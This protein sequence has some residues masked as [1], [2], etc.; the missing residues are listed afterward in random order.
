MKRILLTSTA[1]IAL[2]GTAFAAGH[3]TDH[4]VNIAGDAEI[5]FNDDFE[6]G[7]FYSFGATIT[8]SAEL[9][10]GLTAAASGDVALSDDKNTARASNVTIDDFVMSLTSDTAGLYFGDTPTAAE[11]L[12]SGVTNM[13]FD[14]FVEDGDVDDAA[15][16]DVTGILRGEMGFG[17]F[18]LG[19]SNVLRENATNNDLSVSQI[20]AKGAFGNFSVA[21]AHQTGETTAL[22]DAAGSVNDI[23]GLT[24]GTT[25]GGADVKLSFT[26]RDDA[27]SAAAVATDGSSMGLQI[28]YPV[29]DLTVTAFYVSNDPDTGTMKDNYGL[30]IAYASGPL[31]INA[32]MHDGNDQENLIQIGYDMGNGLTLMAGW[33]DSDGVVEDDGSYIGATYDLGG[34]AS[35]KVVFADGEREG[36]DDEIG[37]DDVKDGL[38]V[39]LSLAF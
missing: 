38:T 32:H 17:A 20:A 16:T 28:A 31:S 39:S 33:E 3:A 35:A 13:E 5:G 12:F 36:L 8:M 2:G 30:A 14:G 1:L 21:F 18:T 7:E 29:G 37:A 9:D 11:S 34:G 10:N 4:G 27:S 6:K 23:T 24:L 22:T 15:D 25:L 26:T 19:V